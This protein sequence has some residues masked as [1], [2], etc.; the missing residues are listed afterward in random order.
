MPN[1]PY[2]SEGEH[3]PQSQP[4]IR[5]QLS[6]PCFEAAV[7][8]MAADDAFP[9]PCKLISTTGPMWIHLER[10]ETMVSR[11]K[12]IQVQTFVK[13]SESEIEALIEKYNL[14]ELDKVLN[15]IFD[16]ELH[17]YFFEEL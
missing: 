15:S 11:L 1:K 5:K 14:G 7:L 8:V 10:L 2:T 6:F 13:G 12:P 4:K 9:T 3:F 16:G 17:D